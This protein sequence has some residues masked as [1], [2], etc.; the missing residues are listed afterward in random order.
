ML[1]LSPN[2]RNHLQT[3]IACYNCCT[4]HPLQDLPIVVQSHNS[5]CHCW[6]CHHSFCG[7]C[8]SQPHPGASC[9]DCPGRVKRMARRRPPLPPDL[10]ERAADMAAAIREREK[11]EAELAFSLS[12]GSSSFCEVRAH[13]E[14]TYSATFLE[15]L[16]LVLDDVE[17]KRVELERKVQD[18]FLRKLSTAGLGELR[19]AFHGT[20]AKNYSSISQRGL[21]VPGLGLGADL[22][23]ANGQAHGRGIYT[24]KVD[25][26]WLSKGFCSEASMLVCAVLDCDGQVKHVHDAMVVQ[27]PAYVVPVFLAVGVWKS[28][29]P[30]LMTAVNAPRPV[31]QP[32][33]PNPKLQA[34]NGQKA[35]KT[36]VE[37]GEAKPKSKPSKFMARLAARS[38]R[39]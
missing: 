2:H 31:P 30:D 39:H 34:K 37:K 32:T 7:L 22:D 19:P 4:L 17:L 25:A 14:H 13:F 1:R 8:R 28:L 11:T 9:F 38:K 20:N 29:M 6:K 21:L 23:V 12:R 5:N 26:A 16:H 18:R 36:K 33:A 35:E 3:S 27:D 10:A 24:A 15:G